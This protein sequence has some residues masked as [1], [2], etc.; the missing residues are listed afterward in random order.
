MPQPKEPKIAIKYIE[1]NANGNIKTSIA[2]DEGPV[3]IIP[4]PKK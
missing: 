1:A 3:L 4:T 2:Q